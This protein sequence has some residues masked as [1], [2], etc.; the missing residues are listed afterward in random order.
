MSIV[1]S[2]FKSS[3]FFHLNW[4]T[5]PYDPKIKPIY[6]Q[7]QKLLN[8]SKYLNI[9]SYS[10]YNLENSLI[11]NFYLLHVF[12][13]DYIS[14]IIELVGKITFLPLTI[15]FE[16]V[17]KDFPDSQTL[18][19]FLNL[20]K[21][22]ISK[23]LSISVQ[24]LDY[25]Y[26][27]DIKYSYLVL[28]P[29]T[30]NNN[31]V[32][33]FHKQFS[34]YSSLLDFQNFIGYQVLHTDPLTRYALEYSYRNNIYSPHNLSVKYVH[35]IAI[36]PVSH[37]NQGYL[38]DQEIINYFDNLIS[39]FKAQGYFCYDFDYFTLSD[40][41]L[42]E[43]LASFWE[44]SIV[45][46]EDISRIVLQTQFDFG[47]SPHLWFH[48]SI[49]N[50]KNNQLPTLMILDNIWVDDSSRSNEYS[51]T[52]GNPYAKEIYA[53]SAIRAY[54]ELSKSEP[55]LQHF[56][57][58]IEIKDN[59][60]LVLPFVSSNNFHRFKQLFK[61]YLHSSQSWSFTSAQNLEEVAIKRL[62]I[63]NHDPLIYSLAF[64]S[65]NKYIIVYNTL[66]AEE[67]KFTYPLFRK[68][69]QTLIQEFNK[70]ISQCNNSSFNNNSSPNNNSSFNNNLDVVNKIIKYNDT[71]S[72][73]NNENSEIT[74][75]IKYI[76]IPESISNNSQH[77]STLFR[78]NNPLYKQFL[79]NSIQGLYSIGPLKGIYSELP[80]TLI[81]KPKYGELK[82]NP[83]SM[84][85][86]EEQ[87]F[88]NIISVDILYPNDIHDSI[89][90]IMSPLNSKL[91]SLLNKLWNSGFFLSNW[92]KAV[93]D[94]LKSP[95]PHIFKNDP[96]LN[97]ASDSKF[98]SS[99]TFNYLS[100]SLSY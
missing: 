48:Q 16:Y 28:T 49:S 35:D 51:L 23:I 45:Y 55:I 6:K 100:Q 93:Q 42:L 67:I 2:Q 94:K 3:E 34:N 98:N 73:D 65:H 85:K 87:Y 9:I 82:L 68:A 14:N 10:S 62:I 8:D 56:I 79:Y 80:P 29:Y 19:Q 90:E 37:T 63:Q 12:D 21:I 17:P 59:L 26:F 44:T 81:I 88:K 13:S 54:S 77:C 96:Y 71:K 92:S 61:Y 40:Y 84:T 66:D 99:A 41:P 78:S 25:S 86:E 39:S 75:L 53:Y 91:E 18:Q 64:Y 38:E 72:D 50:I 58:S 22:Y 89:F 95:S 30:S 69:R 1:T 33:I 43:Q 83:I 70:I 74:K 20:A 60:T 5:D 46:S 76:P 24:S 11:S 47:I 52:Y 97:S 57:T 32:Y 36:F 15:T 4:V 27:S 7:I 31:P